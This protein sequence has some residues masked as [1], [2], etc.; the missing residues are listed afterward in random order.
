MR[1]NSLARFRHNK[2]RGKKLLVFFVL[3]FGVLFAAEARFAVMRVGVVETQ[4]A[5]ILPQNVVLGIIPMW[6][7]RFWPSLWYEREKYQKLVEKFYP[8]K[9]ELKI[10]GW[11]KFCLN[12][13]PLEPEY[14]VYWGEKFWYLSRD[15]KMW[16]SSL[17]ENSV[18]NSHKSDER[19]LLSWAS[20]R[21]TPIDMSDKS[22]SGGNIFA[23]QVPLTLIDSWYEAVGRLGWTH[24]VKY[25]EAGVNE[26][27]PVV[28]IVFLNAKSGNG[29]EFMLPNEAEL[30]AK[31]AL[32]VKKLYGGVGNI[33]EDVFIDGTFG[34][35]ILVKKN[36]R[37]GGAVSES[38]EK[39]KK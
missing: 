34:K 21:A 30:W 39:Q 26:G 2:K 5:H 12:A 7:E 16:L 22:K 17:A 6:Q 27:K 1:S 24:A 33:P 29:A 14:K 32:A 9:A 31:P 19:P 20:D 18:L 23:S 38:K 36:N 10:T 15:G 3:L 13:S 37:V 11:G 8:V 25:I 35:K 28:R 4:P